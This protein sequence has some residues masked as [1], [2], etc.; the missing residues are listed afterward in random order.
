MSK[1]TK[2]I[3]ENSRCPYDDPA[4][5]ISEKTSVFVH[6]GARAAYTTVTWALMGN[7]IPGQSFFASSFLISASLATSYAQYNPRDSLRKALSK[8]G[9]IISTIWIMVSFICLM[10]STPNVGTDG[11]YFTF[12]NHVALK[13]INLTAFSLWWIMGATLVILPVVEWI[14]HISIGE[15]KDVSAITAKGE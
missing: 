15:Q 12:N 5:S 4:L 11:V 7:I 6:L 14:T 10:C 2:K 9:F 1:K 13:N 8:T 3:C